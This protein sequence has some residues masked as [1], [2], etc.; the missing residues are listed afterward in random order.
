MDI[1]NGCTTTTTQP[2][3]KDGKKFSNDNYRAINAIMCGLANS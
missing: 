1:V 2:I 3:D